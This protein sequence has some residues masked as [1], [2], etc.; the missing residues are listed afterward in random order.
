MMIKIDSLIKSYEKNIEIQQLINHN[1]NGKD[2][3]KPYRKIMSDLNFDNN[4]FLFDQ[5]I[6]ILTSLRTAILKSLH[7]I[8][9]FSRLMKLDVRR[10]I[11]WPLINADIDLSATLRKDCDLDRKM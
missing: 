8:H 5:R 3:P 9:N 11:Y 7:S 6:I 4:I 1:L 2:C 10:T